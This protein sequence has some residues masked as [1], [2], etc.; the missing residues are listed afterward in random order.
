MQLTNHRLTNTK[1]NLARLLLCVLYCENHFAPLQRVAFRNC[2]MM[3]DY[4]NHILCILWCYSSV[5][6]HRCQRLSI[7]SSSAARAHIYRGKHKIVDMPPKE[8]PHKDFCT[9]WCS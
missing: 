5:S 1:K 7:P 9:K 8:H 4:K 6:K 3:V 2:A